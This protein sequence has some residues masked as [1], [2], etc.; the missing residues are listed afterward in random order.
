MDVFSS[1]PGSVVAV[2]G[3]GVP[4]SL[5][6]QN[7]SGYLPLKSI[8]TGFEVQTQA[9]VQ[10]MHSLRDFV[11]VYVFGERIASCTISGLS[12]A[13]SCDRVDE[14]APRLGGA[15]GAADFLPSFHGL[16]YALNYYNTNRVSTTG[17]P[18]TIVLGLNTV[19]FGFLIGASV[20]AQDA[21]R[22]VASFSFSFRA[23]PQA[24]LL[25]LLK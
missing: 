9:G 24:T 7:W 22:R 3:D 5:F 10:F 14:R 12:F 18:L 25:D 15:P 4:M 2:P 13:H 23:L 17:A 20:G 19:L 21:E 11:Y 16:E 6:L 1:Q 8:I